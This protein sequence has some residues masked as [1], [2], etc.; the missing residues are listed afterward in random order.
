MDCDNTGTIDRRK[1]LMYLD[2]LKDHHSENS[3]DQ[4]QSMRT[5]EALKTIGDQAPP[6][7]SHESISASSDHEQ[8]ESSTDSSEEEKDD[9][10]DEVSSARSDELVGGT[11]EED[12]VEQQRQQPED[13]G[14]KEEENEGEDESEE[15][16]QKEEKEEEE[17]NSV[18]S[19]EKS[20]DGMEQH[21]QS[22]LFSLIDR[23]SDGRLTITEFIQALRVQPAVSKV[24]LS[25][26]SSFVTLR[27]VG[28]VSPS[29]HQTR[30]RLTRPMCASIQ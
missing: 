4:N 17:D 24:T 9:G 29:H 2:Q 10:E 15:E 22:N 16:E 5:H 30:R 12:E 28:S 19:V 3:H 13:Q 18:H 27:T 20:G 25:S 8:L 14:H 23:N 6:E 11:G 21:P 26:L 7:D 1:F